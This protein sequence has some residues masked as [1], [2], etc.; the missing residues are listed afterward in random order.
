[1]RTGASTGP[2]STISSVIPHPAR[3]IELT[4]TTPVDKVRKWRRVRFSFLSLTGIVWF[5]VEYRQIYLTF[6]LIVQKKSKQKKRTPRSKI[7]GAT[8]C[9]RYDDSRRSW[10]P[11]RG[12]SK[13][14]SPRTLW[15]LGRTIHFFLIS[16]IS[17]LSSL[18]YSN[19]SV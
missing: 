4:A 19:L 8:R 1:M 2:S 14:A 17:Y 13:P 12:F 9:L 11:T 7:D 5:S 18:T 10:T 3:D 15:L 6:L 16:F